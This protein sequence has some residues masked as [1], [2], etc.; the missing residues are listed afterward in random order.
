MGHLEGVP[1]E[2]LRAAL[3]FLDD[4]DP[5][6]RAAYLL[7]T[8]MGRHHAE[9]SLDPLIRNAV[10]KSLSEQLGAP[11]WENNPIPGYD[12]PLTEMERREMFPPLREAA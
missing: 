8:E 1:T 5:K 2:T 10:R 9:E 6:V 3:A 7:G 11:P 4:P 12:R